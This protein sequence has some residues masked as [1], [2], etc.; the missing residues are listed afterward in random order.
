MANNVPTQPA[1]AKAVR[2]GWR[3]LFLSTLAFLVWGY[4]NDGIIGA[5]LLALLGNT[6]ILLLFAWPRK[7]RARSSRARPDLLRAAL[8]QLGR[9]ATKTPEHRGRRLLLDQNTTPVKNTQP[10]PIHTNTVQLADTCP[11]AKPL[12][13]KS[14]GKHSSQDQPQHKWGSRW[15]NPSTL[16][17][18]CGNVAMVDVIAAILLGQFEL[19]VVLA[20]TSPILLSAMLILAF[21]NR[22]VATSKQATV[23]VTNDNQEQARTRPVA[24]ELLPSRR[25]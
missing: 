6:L 4:L 12:G 24:Q 8:A 25:I 11:A 5:A 22:I 17:L 9:A 21:R 13:S 1:D 14:S 23:A 19:V 3:R 2:T 20:I 18:F 15:T 10:V 7:L 16:I